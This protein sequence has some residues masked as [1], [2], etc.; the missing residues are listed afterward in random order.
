M[1]GQ[2]RLLQEGEKSRRLAIVC[3]IGFNY[4]VP[5][6]TYVKNL[7]TGH[8]GTPGENIILICT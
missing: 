4:S 1:P 7:F 3:S 8:T 2:R 6:R 5:N